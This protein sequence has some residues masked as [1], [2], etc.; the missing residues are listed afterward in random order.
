MK[1]QYNLGRSV[2][3]L[4]IEITHAII[5]TL[6]VI[7]LLAFTQMNALVIAV[8]VLLCISNWIRFICWIGD[9]YTRNN[10]QDA[11]EREVENRIVNKIYDE[12]AW[13]KGEK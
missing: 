8:G 13:T 6:W 11:F 1:E 2:L 3:Y 4:I 5:A 10:R 7:G 12:F 9:Q